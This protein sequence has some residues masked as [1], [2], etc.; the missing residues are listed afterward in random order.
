MESVSRQKEIGVFSKS[1]KLM[2]ESRAQSWQRYSFLDQI[3]VE[4]TH[5]VDGRTFY[6]RVLDKNAEYDKID[7]LMARFDP[8][9]AQDLVKPIMKGTLCA[10]KFRSDSKWYRARVMQTMGKGQVQVFFI[11][12]GNSDIINVEDNK[13]IKQLPQDFHKFEAQAKRCELAYI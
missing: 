3:T 6:V 7:K 8:F 11:D 10:A 4:M 2:S 9:T 12:Y 1:L 13:S 5:A